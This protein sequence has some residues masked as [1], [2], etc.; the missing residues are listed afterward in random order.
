ML[1]RA[2]IKELMTLPGIG[3]SIARDLLAL[4]IS[5]VEQLKGQDPELLFE[6]SNQLVGQKQDR[7]LLYTFRCAVYCA[8]TPFDQQ[9]EEK[10]KWWNWKDRK[11]SGLKQVRHP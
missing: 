3:P 6:K 4:G 7:C 8:E 1:E 10:R 2:A 11:P 9:N 5:R